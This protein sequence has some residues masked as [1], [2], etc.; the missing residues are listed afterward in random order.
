MR[1]LAVRAIQPS[2][3]CRGG[4]EGGCRE[5]EVTPSRLLDKWV[6]QVTYYVERTQQL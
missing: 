5:S 4:G 3:Q 6:L 1:V 2:G